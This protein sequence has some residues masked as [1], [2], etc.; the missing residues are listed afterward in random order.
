MLTGSYLEQRNN[1]LKNTVIS[2]DSDA[3]I[4]RGL[5]YNMVSASLLN[6]LPDIPQQNHLKLYKHILY[7]QQCSMLDQ[8]HPELTDTIIAENESQKL[9]HQLRREPS[10]IVTFHTGSYR[11]LNLYLMRGAIPFALVLSS[12]V[13]C[14]QGE[15]IKRIF[16]ECAGG[17]LDLECINAEAANAALLMLGA[18]RRGKSLL[19]Y[20]DGNTGSTAGAENLFP[21]A[22]LNGRLL[23]R[24]GVSVIAHISNRPIHC[25]ATY[26][27]ETDKLNLQYLGEIRPMTGEPRDTFTARSISQI[28]IHLASIVHR[29][30]AQWEAWLYLHKSVHLSAANKALP[31]IQQHN[32]PAAHNF[33]RFNSNEFSTFI[34]D[35]QYYLLHKRSYTFYLIDR[36]LFEC[37]SQGRSESVVMPLAQTVVAE[38]LASGVLMPACLHV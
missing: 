35:E 38:L 5:S 34:V 29:Y 10:I 13:L 9:L 14:R 1:I 20:I 11:L 2:T 30:P 26:Y 28:Y 19:V 15:E 22:F 17:N 37:L 7:Y 6:F 33:Y 32:F 25:M 31:V 16:A 24:K 18:L 23:V 21:T 12:E 3:E 36:C 27:D 8:M 4:L